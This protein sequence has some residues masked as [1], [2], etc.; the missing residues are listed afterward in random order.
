MIVAGIGFNSQCEPQELVDLVRRAEAIGELRAT[1]LAAPAWKLE[2][3][4]L[5]TAA[6]TL[7]LPVVSV[8]EAEL[9][10]VAARCVTVS[11]AAQS[12]ASVGSVAE[13]AA[14]AAAGRSAHLALPRIASRHATCAISM[15]GA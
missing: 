12:R 2:T 14:L 15:G 3:S 7:A 1:T 4:C 6:Q 8:S 13:A 10:T 11:A 5:K 9:A